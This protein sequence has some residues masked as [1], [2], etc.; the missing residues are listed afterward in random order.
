M[1]VVPTYQ[2][3]VREQALEGGFQRAPDV[4]APTRQLG[5][6]LTQVAEAADRI[7]LRDAQAK[8][9]DA[10][11]KITSEWLKWDGQ[12]RQQYRGQNVDQYA[13]AAEAWGNTPATTTARQ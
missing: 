9:F 4:G 3:Q 6:A 5:Q 1:P 12:A 11:A 2:P 13:P 10:E 8:A 7:D